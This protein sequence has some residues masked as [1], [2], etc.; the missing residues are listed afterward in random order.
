MSWIDGWNLWETRT[1]RGF[2]RR[3]H[4]LR[5]KIGSCER[6]QEPKAQEQKQ[7]RITKMS[8]A[9]ARFAIGAGRRL[10]ETRPFLISY[11]R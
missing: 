8:W 11:Q 10:A 4:P 9:L 5:A 3:L 7:A 6:H 2:P 1:C